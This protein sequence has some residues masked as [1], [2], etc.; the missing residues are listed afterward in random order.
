MGVQ[1]EASLRWQQ[2]TAPGSSAPEPDNG[3]DGAYSGKGRGKALWSDC[4]MGQQ[5]GAAAVA[6][7]IAACVHRAMAC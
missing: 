6:N 3:E 7:S 5:L 1:T 4:S 2:T